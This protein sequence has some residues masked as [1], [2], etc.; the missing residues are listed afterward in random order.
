[1]QQPGRP[2][3]FDPDEVLSK[4]MQLFWEHG[5]EA[6][7]LS[8]IIAATGMGKASLYSAF[9]NK[10]SLYLKALAHYEKLVVDA[11]VL[12]LRSREMQPLER[13]D[14]FLSSAVAAVRDHQDRRGCFLCNASADRA[15][16]DPDTA[17]Q[18]RRGYDK[19]RAAI[20]DSLREAF[21]AQ[22]EAVI[23][24]H[25]QLVLT[26]YSGLRIMSR[27][28]TESEEMVRTKDSFLATLSRPEA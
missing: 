4:I 6:T 3:E 18:V 17:S 27:A 12:V 10:K 9:G 2:R 7:G 24:A 13:I 5:Y 15:A 21:P 20:A 14:A 23:A 19:M 8:D 22:P 16:L 11:A 26:V 25:A 28:G 1:M